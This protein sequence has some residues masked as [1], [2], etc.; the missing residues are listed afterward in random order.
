MAT[1][2]PGDPRCA[3]CP[4]DREPGRSP[5]RRLPRGPSEARGDPPRRDAAVGWGP[6]REAAEIAA[7]EAFA[8]GKEYA[9]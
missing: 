1:R 9:E 2:E 3:D 6:T 8:A 5:V 7:F 4:A